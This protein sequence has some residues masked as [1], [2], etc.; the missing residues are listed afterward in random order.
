MIA[1]IDSIPVNW[2]SLDISAAISR[3]RSLVAANRRGKTAVDRRLYRS[4]VALGFAVTY[5]RAQG[6]T[7][8]RMAAE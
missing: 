7:V 6:G 1:T 2:L 3:Q 4:L 8:E 5:A